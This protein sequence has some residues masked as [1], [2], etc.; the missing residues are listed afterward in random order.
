MRDNQA[1]AD[2]LFPWI[3]SDIQSLRERYPV[4][5]EW[6]VVTRIAPSPTGSF[7]LGGLLAAFVPYM[8]AHQEDGVFF[9]RVEDTDQERKVEGGVDFLIAGL[10]DF[11]LDP[12]EGRITEGVDRGDYGP[13][14]QSERLELYRMMARSLIEQGKAYPCWLTTQELDEI[15]EGQMLAKQPP[16]V[17]GEFAPWRDVSTEEVL[18]KIASNEDYV[19]RLRAPY[20]HGERKT[21]PD[22]IRGDVITQAPFVDTVLLKSDGFPTYHL[23]HL[24][25]D[26]LMGTTHIIRAD[27]RLASV[28]LHVTLFEQAGLIPPQYAHIAPLLKSE[29]G[30]KRKLSKR[31]DPEADVRD[32]LARGYAP[33]GILSYLMTIL[34]PNYE[35]WQ[36]DHLES[37]VKDFA[38]NLEG[39]NNSW[40]LVDEE[41]MRQVNREYLARLSCEDLYQEALAW[42]SSHDKELFTLLEKGSDY[43]RDVLNIERH[44]EKDPKRYVLY[45]DIYDQICFFDDGIWE[46]RMVDIVWPEEFEY[47]FIARLLSDYSDR[48]DPSM[49][50]ET[51][52][53][54][55]KEFGQEYGF[56]VNNAQYKE[57]GY[58]GKVGHLAM[59]LRLTLTGTS[60]TP[61]LWSM[62]QI[63]GEERVSGRLK[64]IKKG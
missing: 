60:Q 63:M 19:I 58:I 62:M 3:S 4:R 49:D 32:L 28:P 44:T 50:V 59:L 46:D 17:Y 37:D 1:I 8:Y 11:G 36:N 39:L 18:A 55:L 29:Y 12:D 51:R 16:G 20:A 30:K 35:A 14:Q 52:F 13:Y 5:P 2:A 42:A 57:W 26:R 47:D 34:D 7:H 22:L 40:A 53:A 25:D 61:D 48:Y 54:D 33:G 23:A 31:K 45:T 27:E 38:I 10:H 9:F 64:K 24:V 56:A 21:Y 15:R 41:K 6:Q 43:I